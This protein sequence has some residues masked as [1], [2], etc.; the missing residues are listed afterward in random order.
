VQG[1]YAGVDQALPLQAARGACAGR[2][3]A[4]GFFLARAHAGE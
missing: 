2:A 3:A 1:G 4:Y